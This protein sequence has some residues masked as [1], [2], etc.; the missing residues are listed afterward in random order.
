[1]LHPF[2]PQSAMSHLRTGSA[3]GQTLAR[4]SRSR[5][6]RREQ[7]RYEIANVHA[8]IRHLQCPGAAVPIATRYERVTF[9]P[10]HD[11]ADDASRAG[12]L[13]PKHST[14]AVAV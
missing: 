9:E 10:E 13:A 1:M 4:E 6:S 5:M 11:D 12:L 8:T 7:G 3:Q 14:S 2:D